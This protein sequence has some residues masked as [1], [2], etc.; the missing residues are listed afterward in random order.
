MNSNIKII[1]LSLV[2]IIGLGIWLPSHAE[3]SVGFIENGF[4]M[5]PEL[6]QE[7]AIVSLFATLYNTS[8]Q[9]LSVTVN[10]YD[11]IVYLG[12]KDITVFG[13]DT[14]SASIFWKV[15]AGPHKLSARLLNPTL[16]YT[17]GAREAIYIPEAVLSGPTFT[18]SRVLVTDVLPYASTPE[19]GTIIGQIRLL[20]E[21]ISKIIPTELTDQVGSLF[22]R[23]EY[24]RLDLSARVRAVLDEKKYVK[25][26]FLERTEKEKLSPSYLY[27][28]RP[29]TNLAIFYYT[30]TGFILSRQAAFYGIFLVAFIM[31]VRR[32][33]GIVIYHV[34][35]T[36]KN[37]TKFGVHSH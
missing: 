10:F 1:I 2:V 3:E 36:K 29:L 19:I 30:I 23:I 16:I 13:G 26:G 33:L 27:V 37:S 22:L 28:E 25:M 34:E 14:I 5:S 18:V 24:L 35:H 20:E 31:C 7:G 6:P 17:S 32:L 15:T 12:N 9:N 21:A 11:G 4:F 8:E